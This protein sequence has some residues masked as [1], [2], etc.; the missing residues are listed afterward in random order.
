MKKK[1]LKVKLP[2]LNLRTWLRRLSSVII[3]P[4]ENEACKMRRNVGNTVIAPLEFA[5]SFSPRR[6]ERI[7]KAVWRCVL[8]IPWIFLFLAKIC[9]HARVRN[10]I[11]QLPF[12]ITSHF[13]RKRR[14][15]AFNRR[16][17]YRI[18][19]SKQIS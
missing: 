9:T 10:S 13:F 7:K 2:R 3:I 15:F 1:R 11:T 14:T 18:P 19:F 12:S 17:N 6:D 16:I 5:S 8:A 4:R